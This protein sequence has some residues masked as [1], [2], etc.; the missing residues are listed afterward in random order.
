MPHETRAELRADRT[1]PAPPEAVERRR[2]SPAEARRATRL[3]ESSHATLHIGRGRMEGDVGISGGVTSTRD[4]PAA[5]PV[6][7]RRGSYA[8]TSGLMRRTPIDGRRVARTVLYMNLG[9]TA[10]GRAA[11]RLKV[12]RGSSSGGES[13]Y[14]G[15]E[16]TASRTVFMGVEIGEMGSAAGCG[17]VVGGWWWVTSC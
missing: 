4:G 6:H 12:G 10:K 15:R 17:R 2:A 5:F 1:Q 3:G 11:Q 9:E 14:G 16:H 7:L 13:V 8:T